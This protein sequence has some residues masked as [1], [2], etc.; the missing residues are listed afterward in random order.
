[1]RLIIKIFFSVAVIALSARVTWHLGQDIPI[2]MQSLAV[3]V[4]GALLGWRNGLMA[5]GLY[6]F[7]GAVGL[8]VFADGA[9]GWSVLMGKSAGFLWGFLP[10]TAVVGYLNEIKNKS[11]RLS[12]WLHQFIGTAIILACGV[13]W[14]SKEIGF[15]LALTYGFYP[16]WKGAIIKSILGL[17]IVWVFYFFEKEW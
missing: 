9:S 4:V 17:L 12:F 11:T 5:V 16:F 3:L 1:M 6:L 14:L 7:L 10:A 13:L 15:S 8:P 2:T